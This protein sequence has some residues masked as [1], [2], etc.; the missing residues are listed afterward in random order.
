[1]NVALTDADA[2][3]RDMAPGRYA[4]MVVHDT[5]LGIDAEV[6]CPYL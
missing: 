5:G 4:M 6:L 3:S 2:L 1:M